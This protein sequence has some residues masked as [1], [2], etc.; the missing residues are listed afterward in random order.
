MIYR[1]FGYLRTRLLLYHQDVLRERERSLDIL[2]EE[3]GRDPETERQL[4]SRLL[5]EN[6]ERP[7]R[8]ELF[9]AL[10]QELRTYGRAQHLSRTPSPFPATRT[11][12][13]KTN[14]CLGQQGCISSMSPS[15][16]TAAVLQAFYGTMASWRSPI[17][18]MWPMSMT[19]S[20]LAVTRSIAGS[21]FSLS[22]L[23][24]W[25]AGG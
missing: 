12:M 6:Q 7:R 23:S 8:T 5:D 17:V 25:Q 3:T 22:G 9:R 20:R 11:D 13:G 21:I 16:A 24:R 14:C 2:D 4:C 18:T 10:D 15:T 1:R 19:L